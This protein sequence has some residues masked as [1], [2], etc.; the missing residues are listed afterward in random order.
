MRVLIVDND[1][2]KVKAI[3]EALG[4]RFHLPTVWMARSGQE[5]IKVLSNHKDLQWDQ[6]FLDHYQGLRAP[7]PETLDVIRAG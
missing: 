5:E 6:V 7:F 4:S 1:V 2:S 3:C